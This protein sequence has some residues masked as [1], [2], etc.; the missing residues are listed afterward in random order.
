[1]SID[2]DRALLARA[3]TV[4]F[5][6]GSYSG[7]GTTGQN[8]DTDQRLPAFD[9][10]LAEAGAKIQNAYIILETRFEAYANNPGNYT[11][12]KLAFDTCQEPCT[13]DAFAGSGSG[14]IYKYDT[15]TLAYDNTSNAASNARL[16]LDVTKEAELAAYSGSSTLLSAQVGYRLERGATTASIAF[17]RAMLV[18]T[19]KHYDSQNTNFTNTVVYPLESNRAGDSGSLGILQGTACTTGPSGT[20]PRFNY[21]MVIPEYK[22]RL[23]QWYETFNEYRG[24]TNANLGDVT[25]F[26]DVYGTYAPSPLSYIHEGVLGS[27]QGA[28]PPVYFD[29]VSGFAE[30]T[31]QT[32]EYSA[33][34][35]TNGYYAIGG[36]V[37][38]TYIASSSASVK[39]RTASFPLGVI[40]NGAVTTQVVG[41]TNVYLP[42]NGAATGTV[43]IKK[44]WFRIV[45][46]YYSNAAA[47]QISVVSKTGTRAT[48]APAVTYA[49]RMS[50]LT[51]KPSF[52]LI[53]VIPSANYAELENANASVPVEVDL[54][55][56]N[57]AATAGGSAAELMITYTYTDES[58]GHLSS[59]NL[60]GGQT[61]FFNGTATASPIRLVLP[62]PPGTKT[63]LAGS[64]LSSF[65]FST[66]TGVLTS[67]TLFNVDANISTG[68][69][70]CTP[71]YNTRA[72]GVNE[73]L[74]YYKNVTSALTTNAGENVYACYANTFVG[75]KANGQ[76]LYTYKWDAPPALLNQH[77]WQWFDQSSSIDPTVA[78]AAT[79]TSISN[80]NIGDAVRLRMNID[81]AEENISSSSQAFD[82]Q[83]STTTGVCTSSASWFD[84]GT[85]TA[86]TAWRSATTSGLADG[87]TGGSALLQTSS[88]FESYEDS[89]PSILN[90][91]PLDKGETGE[92]DW[93]IY[94]YNA[95]SLQNYCFRM[96]KSDGTVLAS[97]GS[98][99]KI[100][101]AASN[102]SPFDPFDLLQYKVATTANISVIEGWTNESQVRLA[103]S[104]TDVNLSQRLRFFFQATTSGN[105]IVATTVPANVCAY[106]TAWN[107]CGS[108]IW[109]A[110]SSLGDYRVNPFSTTTLIT[111]LPQNSTTGYK[112]QVLACDNINMCSA[113]SSTG[114]PLTLPNFYVDTTSPSVPAAMSWVASSGVSITLKLS[115]TTEANF[116]NYKIFYKA[117]T[118]T[119]PTEKDNLWTEA[120]FSNI[121]FNGATTTTIDNLAAATQYIFNIWAYDKAGNVA[122]SASN[123]ATTAPTWN[124]PTLATATIS[125]LVDGTG[126]IRTSIIADDPDNNN[127]L[128]IK[129]EYE[130]G[131]SC[132]FSSSNKPT[133]SPTTTATYGSPKIDNAQAYQ[134]GTSTGYIWTAPGENTVTFDW[135]SKLNVSAATGTYCFRF[136]ANDG[137][138]DGTPVKKAF[139]LD[140][141]PPTAPSALSLKT[142]TADS[143]TLNLS[144]QVSTDDNPPSYSNPSVHAYRIFYSTTDPVLETDTELIDSDLLSY[145]FSG[146]T[147]TIINDLNPNT[148][149]Y[150]NIW[151]YDDFGNKA[152]STRVS[153]KTDAYPTQPAAINQYKADGSTVIAN[154][155]WTNQNTVK[156][157]ASTTDSDT[158]EVLSL[159]YELVSSSSIF[160]TATTVPANVCT[161][162]QAYT[163]C[164]S[165]IWVATSSGNFSVTPFT[166][167]ATI[168]NLPENT[169]A[170]GYKWQVMACDQNGMCSSWTKFNLSAPNFRVD[171]VAPAL[172]AD[173]LVWNSQTSNTVVFTL[174]TTA[175]ETNFDR[176]ELHYGTAN[177][178]T[179][180]DAS[181][182]DQNFSYLNYN[183]A[184]LTVVQNLQPATQTYFNLWVFDKA[185]N[186]SSSSIE[187]VTLNPMAGTPGVMF[188]AKASST[189]YY[190]TWA[191][192]TGWSAEKLGPRLGANNIR[193]LAVLSSDD[194]GKVAILAKTW[195]G[196][197]QQ[198]W[199]A[200]YKVAADTF[201]STSQLGSQ[202]ASTL[203]SSN[204]SGCLG[205]LSGGQFIAVRNNNGT[206]N[207]PMNLY[208]WDAVSGWATSSITI[209]P[210]TLNFYGGCRLV[211]RPNTD[212]YLLMMY[213][214]QPRTHSVYYTGGSTYADG[215]WVKYYA[216]STANETSV[217][218]YVGSAFFDPNLNTRGAL[219]YTNS[220]TT[221]YVYGNKFAVTNTDY[222]DI[223]ATTSPQTAPWS[224]NTD[225]VHGEFGVDN[226]LTGQAYYAG[227][228]TSG[229]LNVYRLD[230]TNSLPVW[231]T[232][233]A[234]INISSSSVYSHLNFAQKPF[235]I[236]FYKNY[237]G[238]VAY[239]ATSSTN[240]KYRLLDSQANALSTSSLNVPG[241]A[242]AVWNRVNLI[243][244][245]N[246]IQLL[247]V[248]QSTSSQYATIFFNGSK[249]SFFPANTP[250]R[251]TDIASSTGIFDVD[252]S[253]TA[254]SYTALNSAPN[255]PS[256]LAQLKAN[257]TTTIVNGGWTNQATTTLVMSAKDPDTSEI[258]GLYL[259]VID[260]NAAF[261]SSTTVPVGACASTTLYNN[262]ATNIWFIAS[263]TQGDYSAV[264][265]TA[266]ATIAG[267]P[268]SSSTVPGFKWQVIACDKAGACSGWSEFNATV[269]N[270]R[271]DTINPT[272]PGNLSIA[273]VTSNAVT[274]AFGAMAT[275]TNFSTYK[276]FYKQAA[277]G[278]TENDTQWVDADLG[279]R[280]YN[281]TSTT[282]VTGLTPGLPY[283]FRIW[284]YDAAGNKASSAAETA[285]T[286][287][288]PPVLYQ[289]SYVFENDDGATANLNS[290][291]TQASTTLTGVMRGERIN[292]RIQ[293]ENRGGDV[294]NKAY[295]LE[296][297]SSANPN[298]WYAVGSVD[299]LGVNRIDSSMAL[300]GASGDAVTS[301]KATANAKT[302]INGR[303]YENTNQSGT[304]TIANNYYT[305][306]VFAIAAAPTIATGTTYR[307][308]LWNVTD[309]AA[310]NGYDNYPRLQTINTDMVNRLS[311][312]AQASLPAIKN[313]LTYYLDHRG[314]SETIYN[315]GA[316]RDTLVTNSNYGIFNFVTK[317]ATNT[318]AITASWDGQ[319]TV[320]FGT[321]PIYLQAYSASTSN[322]VTV[323]SNTSGLANADITLS[324]SLN[325]NLGSFYD[326]ANYTYWRIYQNTATVS[327]KT[328]YATTTFSAPNPDVFQKHYRF[329]NDDGGQ[330]TSTA[331]AAEDTATTTAIGTVV[332]VRMS[333]V[334]LGGGAASNYQYQLEYSTTSAGCAYDVG[335]WRAVPTTTNKT[336]EFRMATTSRF[337]D[338]ASTTQRLANAE[339]YIFGASTT[340]GAGHMVS[341]SSNK[342]LNNTLR[343][344]YYVENEYAIMASTSA[345]SG[346]TYC[347]RMTNNGTPLNGYKNGSD[348]VYAELTI[349]G[350]I[351]TGPVFT[352]SPIDDGADS[353]SPVDIGST[354]TFAGTATDTEGNDYYLAICKSA[355]IMPGN[356]SAPTCLNGSW[357]V[358]AAA[359]SSVEATC[360]YLTATT[361]EVVDW[362]AY[363]CDQKLGVG[364]AKCSTSTAGYNGN[365]FDSPFYL[366]HR[367]VLTSI[368]TYA[369][370]TTP[371]QLYTINS[372][373]SDPDTLNGADTLNFIVCRTNSAGPGGCTNNDQVCASSTGGSNISCSFTPPIPTAAGTTN[374]YGFLFDE[375]GLAASTSPKN[376]S[377]VIS[378]TKPDLGTLNFVGLPVI[379]GSS[380][381]VLNLRGSDTPVAVTISMSD[382]NGCTDIT[383]ATAKIYM[384]ATSSS[385]SA[386]D[387]NVCYAAASP[388]DCTK[389]NCIAGSATANYTCTTSLKYFALSTDSY[390]AST[391]QYGWLSS[392]NVY[393]SAVNISF[394]SSTGVEL[395][396]NLGIDVTEP[397]IDFGSYLYAGQNSASKNSTS[398]VVNI[399]NSPLNVDLSGSDMYAG[400]GAPLAVN[401][402][403]WKLGTNFS[404]G[405]GF[406]LSSV[407]TTVPANIQKATTTTDTWKRFLWGIG[408][409][410][411][412]N[413]TSYNGT[414][415]FIAVPTGSGWW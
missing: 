55:L 25:V 280:N 184:T 349:S 164:A 415:T 257:A 251:W 93:S 259:E 365:E 333:A 340:A 192:S 232:T 98:Y 366:N 335:T 96:V 346:A 158:S 344:G 207:P 414:T 244:D 298:S 357:C 264:P 50:A 168:S 1:V 94:N 384:S 22:N 124:P 269:P 394:A 233:A 376:S 228:D 137:S 373:S 250:Q 144:S 247:A 296:Y 191:S 204:V 286:T 360:D 292:V 253:A 41:K 54:G 325:A 146:A 16:I 281:N 203:G 34:G 378:N 297:E 126:S 196:T 174:A 291:S 408:V 177:P 5:P 119:I 248:Y 46:N 186:M 289:T 29:N 411:N 104:V 375:H 265:F 288:N 63:M 210:T 194:K 27:G 274:L 216:Q 12:Y 332:R 165:H 395:V 142:R 243:R 6:A 227:R 383:S 396:S 300:S 369:P 48:T 24:G 308:R 236:E 19:Y 163:N 348:N 279:F 278:V 361:S 362:V 271:V 64:L 133:L 379:N 87:S 187:T 221:A 359:S 402:L 356:N 102:T 13:P 255:T 83:Y 112:W 200:V 70:S 89:N 301:T 60:F 65:L 33:T 72:D 205:S 160:T 213:S 51:T 130:A 320:D 140:T 385:C 321:S 380:S 175:V 45:P 136:T 10:S 7:G 109:S 249:D 355:G 26:V 157:V 287:N 58:K 305:E 69:P 237:H 167:T 342:T 3:N 212:N 180:A 282:T 71:S 261:N 235:D 4:Y 151:A 95:S 170:N 31:A 329:F 39:T 345:V 214:S 17:A 268:E 85:S 61:N 178:V 122:S 401:N 407:A 57:N 273:N 410:S 211:R 242:T 74:E 256:N 374:Y 193:H 120:N 397:L 413:S 182:S 43:S 172:A 238:I 224:W 368:S 21:N 143:L 155:S 352:V 262:C 338:Q 307:L 241:S 78:L 56:T 389:T 222:S 284:S 148:T 314:Y 9:F 190:R 138:F 354:I 290:T 388:V 92:W 231:A 179:L 347:F 183:G 15:S 173:A 20:C 66:S 108:K 198:W 310:L 390:N 293:L 218:N 326:S 358:S 145:D 386:L 276:I 132:L 398:T 23:S 285:T 364:V 77:D 234:G 371:G 86:A 73:Y 328:D 331:M 185:G 40:T 127:T 391:T 267:I 181:S 2:T 403:Q 327:L 62:E 409:P 404:Y 8:S 106:G 114:T 341:S 37:A 283:V 316:N 370:T 18:V 322:W 42:E 97:Y 372:V 363:A 123:I 131:G 169:I 392:I 343:E 52:N 176:Y 35:G 47:Q 111:G 152:S 90:P 11:G 254:F 311:K 189:L 171:T 154:G 206:A 162:T 381:I 240:P 209:S 245:P 38:E 84:L 336:L 330:S 153:Y 68:T 272:S 103:A 199:G 275:D 323:A 156:L 36:E 400:M 230:I 399:G 229:W 315:D 76:L 405:T 53:Y 82:L 412:A 266:T 128:R 91:L 113:W 260:S 299:G 252:D 339:G 223:P 197:N 306:L 246:E 149:Y 387:K 324:G 135:L 188:Y 406:S 81:V 88:K 118:T 121:L 319:S 317:A 318:Q 294:A 258:I 79:N 44:A 125:Q 49:Y 161:S 393:D 115:T 202:F 116:S 75:A 100:L 334:N 350:N 117:A 105:F 219:A 67:G 295:R 215:T 134:V 239:N 139:Y 201:V 382:L 80:I 110:T 99:P 309:N 129:V 208:T 367:P 225:V 220:N 30:N 150:I 14:N 303:F 166:A 32:I 226:A 217:D 304:V 195:D 353:F 313:D 377:Y 351:N 101:T 28:M 270:F 312:A 263:S 147:T 159:Y 277:S 302:W 141:V 59:L 337:I 107:T